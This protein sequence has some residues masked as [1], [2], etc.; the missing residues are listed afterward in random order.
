MGVPAHMLPHTVVRVRAATT[1]DAYNNTVQD[2]GAGADRVEMAGWLQQDS[3]KEPRSDGRDPLEQVWLLVTN[4]D[5]VLG[6]D[7]FE[8]L[9]LTFEVEG[10]PAPVHT[11]AGYHH[12]ETTLRVVTG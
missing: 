9:G 1:T 10:P 11:P 7:R 2:W 3:R 4:D 5:D 12:T 6:T 8:G